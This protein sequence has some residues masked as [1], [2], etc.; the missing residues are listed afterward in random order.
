VSET[1]A[2]Q[3]GES[4]QGEVESVHFTRWSAFEVLRGISGAP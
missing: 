4:H 2:F 1:T 3:E